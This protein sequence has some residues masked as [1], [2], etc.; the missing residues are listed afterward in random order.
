[1]IP[2]DK[3][4]VLLA[5]SHPLFREAVRAALSAQ[6]GLAVVAEA[7]DGLAAIKEARR[8]RPQLA[9]LDAYLPKADGARSASLIRMDV[10]ECGV[11]I[12]GN[13]DDEQALVRA[14]E[15]GAAG[16]VTKTSGLTELIAT[17]HSVSRGRTVVPDDMLS[18]LISGLL[19]RRNAQSQALLKL[20]RLTKREREV[21]ALLANG[22]R[23]NDIAT[24]LTISPQTART[25]IQNIL[26]KL[27]VHSRLQ[28]AAFVTMNGI[29]EQLSEHAFRNDRWGDA[30]GSGGY[31]GR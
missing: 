20:S 11:I 21:L 23:N 3:I 16:Y 8:T 13:A 14:I 31:R 9:I 26:G 17:A 24:E 5:D 29:L 2:S 27:G 12:L 4:R 30:A 28:A 10:P 1:M 19:W 25:H 6:A 7:D 15:A 18:G 22:A